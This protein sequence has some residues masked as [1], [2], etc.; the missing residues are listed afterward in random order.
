MFHNFPVEQQRHSLGDSFKIHAVHIHE[1]NLFAQ[2][3]ALDEYGSRFVTGFLKPIAF[4][5]H[6]TALLK[7]L[8]AFMWMQQYLTG[9]LDFPEMRFGIWVQWVF[10]GMKLQRQFPKG[11]FDFVPGCCFRKVQYAIVIFQKRVQIYSIELL[12]QQVIPILAVMFR[13]LI[14]IML[15][16]GGRTYGADSSTVD[17]PLKGYKKWFYKLV[18]L[19]PQIN[20]KVERQLLR[21]YLCGNGA[22]F[23]LNDR[24]FERLQQL[25]RQRSREK[26][27]TIAAGTPFCAA[28]VSL[29]DDGYFG[30][31]LGS[32]TCVFD[33]GCRRLISFA[34]IYDFNPKKMGKRS[35]KLELYTRVFRWVAPRSARPF[36][37]SYGKAAYWTQT[38]TT[39]SG[40]L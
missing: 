1:C 11:F 38:G 17:C 32:V 27:E 14:C 33:A 29:N 6:G 19:H 9:F 20:S 13:L 2:F 34:D 36:L 23:L 40:S 24:D 25:V 21:H 16:L 4:C 10:V 26:N 18:I 39:V 35:L 8:F 28:T 37:V 3:K 30:W 12:R 7:V 5:F 31:G 15:L 22:T